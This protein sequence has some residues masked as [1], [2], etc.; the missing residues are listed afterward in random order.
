ML[1]YPLSLTY[2]LTFILLFSVICVHTILYHVYMFYMDNKSMSYF[3]C[4]I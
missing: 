4:F 3:L 1:D 2:I